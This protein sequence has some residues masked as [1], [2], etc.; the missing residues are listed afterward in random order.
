[1]SLRN[2]DFDAVF[3]RVAER[4]IEEA[5]KEGKF[6]NLPGAGQPL[7]IDAAPAD[8]DARA[9]WWAIRILKQND[10]TPDEIKWRR[11]ID[12]LRAELHRANQ[13]AHVRKVVATLNGLIRKVNTMGTN[14]LHA[15]VYEV[16]LDRA[17]ADARA[18]A[19]RDGVAFGE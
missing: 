16:D 5:I 15:A 4:R 17:L 11:T 18:R 7:E 10:I 8:E 2:I 12:A 3:R 9:R 1:M 14:A 13:A 6:D 19:A